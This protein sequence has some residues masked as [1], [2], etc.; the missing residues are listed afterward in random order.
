MLI[1]PDLADKEIV[2]CL[3]HEYRLDVKLISFLPIGADFN[4]AV[5][6]VTTSNQTDY[7]LKLRHGEFMMLQF[8]LLNIWLP[9]TS[10]K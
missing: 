8:Q 5:Y 10:S 3:R 1:K 2:R 4:T 9:W 6:G 7:F